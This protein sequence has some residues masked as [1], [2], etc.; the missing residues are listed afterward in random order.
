M[1]VNYAALGD[2]FLRRLAAGATAELARR[3]AEAA[4]RGRAAD[5]RVLGLA[6]RLLRACAWCRKV[7]DDRQAWRDLEGFVH[8]LT[9]MEF[10][11]GICPECLGRH[12]FGT[13]DAE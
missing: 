13:P 11:H 9:G 12:H 5:G 4:R 2:E 10:T 1:A 8:A 6:Q 3:K 7:Q